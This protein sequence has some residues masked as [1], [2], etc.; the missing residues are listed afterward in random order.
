MNQ[1]EIAAE[2]RANPEWQGPAL[3]FLKWRLASVQTTPW[4]TVHLF[5]GFV[6]GMEAGIHNPGFAS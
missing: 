2:R 5:Q 1:L 4:A 3:P 6:P